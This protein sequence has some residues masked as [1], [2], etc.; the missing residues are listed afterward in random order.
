ME[1]INFDIRVLD[2]CQ[3]ADIFC[4]LSYAFAVLITRDSPCLV[5]A[6][7]RTITDCL[8]AGGCNGTIDENHAA[9][10]EQTIDKHQE[11]RQNQGELKQTLAG[12]MMLENFIN[13]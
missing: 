2:V 13:P 8:A 3:E 4:R 1:V 7:R 10:F 9:H 11:N 5:Q 6:G 12:G